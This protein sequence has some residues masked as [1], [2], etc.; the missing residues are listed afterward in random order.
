MTKSNFAMEVVQKLLTKHLMHFEG[1]RLE[2]NVILG[3]GKVNSLNPQNK[4]D[5]SYNFFSIIILICF[6]FVSCS[7]LCSRMVR[8]L[9]KITIDL[10]PTRKIKMDI[11]SHQTACRWASCLI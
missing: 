8:I 11:C 4:S 2:R 10:N 7:V 9:N 1:E 6:V 3:I 5:E